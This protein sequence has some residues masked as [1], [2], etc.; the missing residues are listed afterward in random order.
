MPVQIQDLCGFRPSDGDFVPSVSLPLRWTEAL[1]VHIVLCSRGSRRG[2]DKS[3]IVIGT[4]TFFYLLQEE[5]ETRDYQEIKIQEQVYSKSFHIDS[6]IHIEFVTMQVD[7]LD[8]GTIP[9]SITVILENDLVD[10]CQVHMLTMRPAGIVWTMAK[11]LW[12][13]S[14]PIPYIYPHS[15][16]QLSALKR[17]HRMLSGCLPSDRLIDAAARAPS[18]GDGDGAAPLEAPRGAAAGGHQPGPR[19]QS[20][21]H[22]QRPHR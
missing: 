5:R 19:R 15:F 3:V 1:Q 6:S 17:S 7:M 22:P 11:V 13:Q 10:S 20:R 14:I 12:L 18:G 21:R 2:L 4:L 9:R 16:L 8:V